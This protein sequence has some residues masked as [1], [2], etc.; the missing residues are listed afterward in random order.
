VVL[1]G[2]PS[3]GTWT[4]TRIPGGATIT[5]NGTGATIAALASGTHTFTVTNASG[6]TSTSSNNVVVGVQPSTPSAPAI[7]TITQPTYNVSTGSVVLNGL[8]NAGTWTLTR[9]PGGTTTSGSGT[10]TTI[11]P[12]EAGAYTFTVTNASGCVSPASAIVSLNSLKLF[13]PNNAILNPEDTIDLNQ[14]GAGSISISVESNADWSVSDD[15][16]W[17]HTVKGSG[18]STIVITF[19][20]NISA[21][22]KVAAFKVKYALNPEIAVYLHQKARV[23]HLNGSKFENVIIY[24]NPASES[25]YLNPGKEEFEKITISIADIQGHTLSSKRYNNLTSNQIIEMSLSGLP[26][27]QYF[28]NIGDGTD[29]KIFRII[30]Y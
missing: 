6:C 20:E 5:G 8:P 23:S 3:T 25:V 29:H 30:K 19:M 18:N 24:P 14:S 1:N 10:S 22:D 2:L 15:A 13:G 4:L 7:G 27:G 12:L 11:S 26:V 16:V 17:F 28:L 9:M 21:L